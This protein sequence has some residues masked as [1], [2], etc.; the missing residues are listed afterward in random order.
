[1]S[2]NNSKDS[3]YFYNHTIYRAILTIAISKFDE[4]L[5]DLRSFIWN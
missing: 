4:Y 2:I 3:K 5:K 1:M